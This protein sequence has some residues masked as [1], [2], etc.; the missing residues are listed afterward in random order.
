MSKYPVPDS[1]RSLSPAHPPRLSVLPNETLRIRAMSNPINSRLP[2]PKTRL[3][4]K[5]EAIRRKLE[6]EQSRK[7]S[8]TAPSSSVNVVKRKP[9]A[10]K[11]TL[12]ALRPSPALTVLETTS[13]AEASRLCATKRANCILVADEEEGLT[14][15]FT[16]KDLTYRVIAEGLDPRTTILRQVMTP[17]PVVTRDTSTVT[18]ALELMVSNKIRHLPIYSEDESIV[19]VA[20]LTKVFHETLGNA[21]RRSLASEQLFSA[22]TG[23]AT[24]IGT[25]ADM[26]AWAA[27]LR[28]KTTLPDLALALGSLGP[29]A[30]IGPKTSVRTAAQ[31]MKENDTSA[32]CVI[33]ETTLSPGSGRRSPRLVG[34]LTCED[35]L[36]RVIAAGL[37]AS[38]CSV[39]RVMALR[40]ETIIPTTNNQRSHVAVADE[41][42]HLLAIVN[43][44]SLAEAS[45][46]QIRASNEDLAIPETTTESRPMLGRFLES[47][48][49]DTP[50][51]EHSTEPPVPSHEDVP[52]SPRSEASTSDSMTVV[53]ELS[54]MS[55]SPKSLKDLPLGGDIH[56]PREFFKA[57]PMG[58][59]PFVSPQISPSNSMT[60]ETYVFKFTSPGG[61]THRLEAR[62]DDSKGLK[63]M[64]VEKLVTD[65]LFNSTSVPDASNRPD[66][67]DFGLFYKD[68]DGDDVAITD[69]N[70]VRHAVAASKKQGTDRV[71]LIVK[72]G[73]NWVA[74]GESSSGVKEVAAALPP[75]SQTTPELSQAVEPPR[76]EFPV[77]QD[78][79]PRYTPK[80]TTEEVMTQ[81]G[82]AQV[83]TPTQV[84]TF[85]VQVSPEPATVKQGLPLNLFPLKAGS[86]EPDVRK[87]ERSPPP[88]TFPLDEKH[89]LTPT[90]AP[91]SSTR[92]GRSEDGATAKR[93][94]ELVIR[95]ATIFEDVVQYKSLLLCQDADAQKLLDAFQTLLDTPGLG[96]KFKGNLT[97]ATQRLSRRAGLYPT[98]YNLEDVEMVEDSPIAAGSFADIYK[99]SFLGQAVCLKVIRVYQ[100][101]NFQS[102]LK[103]MELRAAV[104]GRGYHLGTIIALEPSSCLRTLSL[105]WAPLS[106]FAVDA[107]WRHQ[108][109]YQRTSPYS[110]IL[111]WTANSSAGS[112]G[113]SIR[114]QA[115]EL[116]DVEK[117]E[118]V[119]NTNASDVYAFS[120]VA[121]ELFTGNL[122]FFEQAREPAVMIKVRDGELPSKPDPSNLAWSVWGLNETTWSLMQSCWHRDPAR[123]P[124]I[125]EIVSYFQSMIHVDDRPLDSDDLVLTPTHFRD[126]VGGRADLPSV[127]DLDNILKRSGHGYEAIPSASPLPTDG[128]KQLDNVLEA[129]W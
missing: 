1:K 85:P 67:H 92:G 20:D 24:E 68:E 31:I 89:R 104:F 105:Q 52:L 17:D 32:V 34:I 21:Q 44:L 16:A 107:K 64:V 27:K 63:K 121:Y 50:A 14:G 113:G 5:D 40:P 51:S 55:M 79:P 109:L 123:R 46:D 122:P 95:L 112:R 127:A 124:K 28:A 117:D 42:E 72:G 48:R 129:T 90:I 56:S 74:T 73:R 82:I 30:T 94:K 76:V 87:S 53:D 103:L 18:D 106:R 81:V 116:F 93:I 19:G 2:Q 65:P 10:P 84:I 58:H 47:I 22:M 70:N 114:W 120:C 125:H 7:R 45:Q 39:V 61:I 78:A 43:I 91:N 111:H 115:P 83:S 102:F 88:P 41:G 97:V 6:T 15:V 29:P 119:H 118:V 54:A 35:I 60:G 126:S 8:A 36:L 80:S 9:A 23:V 108:P 66:P 128:I 33:E 62:S 3:A 100:N 4:Q 57:L 69:D 96:P 77:I 86:S 99:G 75:V 38:Y 101:S 11:G 25:S 71:M 13:V 26:L 12:A 49:S 59:S 37:D 110:E 98:C